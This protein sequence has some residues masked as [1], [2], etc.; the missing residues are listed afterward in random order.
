MADADGGRYRAAFASCKPTLEA[1]AKASDESG[2]LAARTWWVTCMG[3]HLDVCRSAYEQW[4]TEAMEVLPR[5]LTAE[6]TETAVRLSG[7]EPMAQCVLE[8]GAA[9][10]VQPDRTLDHV[11]QAGQ[12]HQAVSEWTRATTE[13]SPLREALQK[14]FLTGRFG[15]SKMA[16]TAGEMNV[17]ELRVCQ[18]YV[19]GLATRLRACGQAASAFASEA[20][21]RD[22]NSPLVGYNEE[23]WDPTADVWKRMEM[24]VHTAADAAGSTTDAAWRQKQ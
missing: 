10:G 13:V 9:V 15:G 3:S 16:K 2:R 4:R 11:E 8:C 19:Y 21:M 6:H 14:S 5:Q 17:D 7:F 18:I 1:L 23:R 12:Q 24:C 22:P 20:G